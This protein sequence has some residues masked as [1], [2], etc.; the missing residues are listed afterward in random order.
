LAALL[1]AHL[2]AFGTDEEGRLFVGLHGGQLAAVTYTRLW[3]RARKAAL[4]AEQVSSP[5]AKRPYDLRHAAVSTWLSSGVAPAQVAEWA[6]HSVEVLL[7]TYA[8]CL[9]GQE[10]AALSQIEQALAP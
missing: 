2:E 9:D 1:R 7:R 4:T 10:D 6:G 5:L 8:K 3:N